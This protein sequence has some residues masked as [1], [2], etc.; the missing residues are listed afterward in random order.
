MNRVMPEVVLVSQACLASG[1]GW[2]RLTLVVGQSEASV[3][4][5]GSGFELSKSVHRLAGFCRLSPVL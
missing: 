3:T 4:P 5:S 1:G 2:E